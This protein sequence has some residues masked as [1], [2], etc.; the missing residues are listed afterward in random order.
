M[1][2][3]IL[4][5]LFLCPLLATAQMKVVAEGP[6]FDEPEDGCARILMLKNGG[7]AFVR[8]TK[9]DGIDIRLYDGQHKQI[10]VKTLDPDYGKLKA[11][12]VEGMYDVNG[13]IN[14]FISEVQDAV[15]VL[16]RLR[17]DEQTG[18]LKELKT[19]ATLNKTSMGQ[20]YAMAFGGVPMPDFIVR[21]DPAS[22]NYAVVRYNTFESD[23]S[24]RVELIQYGADGSEV[25]RNFLSSPEGKYKYTQI[26]DFATVGNRVYGLLYSYNTASSG[27]AA[28]EL[29]LAT[30]ENDQVSYA[31]VGKSISR[32]ID[33]G[34]LR[35]NPV[36]KN[37]IFLTS[38]LTGVKQ[39]WN[40]A[41]AE[42]S[43][44]FSV[45]D[46]ENPGIK[47]SL[48]FRRSSIAAKYRKIFRGKDDKFAPMPEQ[49]YINN[50]GSFTVLLEEV[51]QIERTTMRNGIPS[52]THNAGVMLGSA[53][54]IT[55]N[56]DGTERS[57]VLIPKS[58]T[59]YAG[60]FDG[61]SEYV[62][63]GSFYIAVRDN[64]ASTLSAGNQYKSL[65]YFN[66]KNKSYV[67]LNDI[68]ENAERVEKGK[69]T[70]IRGVGDCDAWVY[71][72]TTEVS[73]KLPI[74]QRSP[75]FTKERSKDRNL[76]LFNLSGFDR[77]AGVYATL[78]LERGKGVKMV[79][80][81]E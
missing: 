21:K 52:G 67:M 55:I 36:T 23:R 80:M 53:A 57:A 7:T 3:I 18:A 32:R 22:D 25:A 56:E 31:N 1:K 47:A 79:W 73:A 13:E 2:K 29:L 24:K 66:G 44:Q 64:G 63:A 69:L 62:S 5:L 17:V 28:N 15:P 11:M 81:S 26:L 70:N 54:V 6:S 37:L 42:Y 78:K 40:K 65:S 49:L 51:T 72:L 48:D 43:I 71:D 19:I 45:I 12:S 39:G 30:V 76:A 61:V 10:A 74:P 20:G 35:Y 59:T 77:E 46:P 50:D 34:I 75:L 68:E 41:T 14:L 4:S 9:K 33:D 27:G 60:M 8:A 58:Q 16:Y 38:E